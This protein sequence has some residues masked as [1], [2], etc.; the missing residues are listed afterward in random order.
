MGASFRR[1]TN[2]SLSLRP[3]GLLAI[4]TDRT[5]WS[6]APATPTMAF[7][8]PARRH[9][10]T[11]VPV[12]YATAPNQ[13]LRWRDFHP[14]VQQPDS[15]HT[16]FF[17]ITPLIRLTN[18]GIRE[19]REDLVEAARAFGASETRVL[20]GIQLPLAR[21]TILAGLNQTVLLS[22]SMAVVASMISV[23]GL[24]ELCWKVSGGSISD[25]PPWA[26]SASC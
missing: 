4:L 15:L 8:V 18:L 20:F 22:L 21:P 6:V 2:R 23:P 5:G 17:A 9:R 7:Y 11:P 14:R 26:V 19:V 1:I 25:R 16:C 10:V 12:G 24:G 13:E 3:S